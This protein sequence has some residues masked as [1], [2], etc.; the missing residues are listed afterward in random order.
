MRHTAPLILLALPLSACLMVREPERLEPIRAYSPADSHQRIAATA[1]APQSLEQGR[2]N[3]KRLQ[4]ERDRLDRIARAALDAS[5]PQAPNQLVLSRL[6]FRPGSRE[7]L[8]YAEHYRGIPLRTAPVVVEIENGQ[9]V[10]IE[11]ERHLLA[12]DFSIEPAIDALSAEEL[13]R[14]YI[15]ALPNAE[16]F[17]KLVILPDEESGERYRLV[18]R[19]DLPGQRVWVDAMN[20]RMLRHERRDQQENPSPR[21]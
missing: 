20:G 13:A 16:A 3:S 8:E 12:E 5:D 10:A 15:N 7:R 19:I 4:R 6:L 21:P 18:W 1:S 11:G 14:I 17:S 9:V 2:L